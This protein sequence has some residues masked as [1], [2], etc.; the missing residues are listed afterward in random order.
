MRA[1]GATAPSKW[2][3]GQGVETEIED[4]VSGVL[5]SG[6]KHL[7]Q[8]AHRNFNN[9]FHHSLVFFPKPSNADTV[10]DLWFLF[11]KTL[12]LSDQKQ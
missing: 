8:I 4:T 11:L 9:S 1:V 3:S 2:E 12:Q 10:Y 7:N 6:H 5:V